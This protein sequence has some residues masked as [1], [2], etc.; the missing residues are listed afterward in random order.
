MLAQ[1]LDAACLAPS[2]GYSQ[3]WRFVSVESGQARAAV[4]SNFER[5]N[6]EALNDYH[7]ERA[8]LYAGL[9]LAGLRVAPVQLAVFTD[10]ATSVGH[11]LGRK[12]MPETLTY[13]TVMAIQN[14][15][16]QR[17][18][19]M[20][21]SGGCRFSIRNCSG[22]ISMFLRHGALRLIYVS[23]IQRKRLIN[24]SS[25]AAA[26]NSYTDPRAKS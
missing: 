10:A 2:V 4:R 18:P 23:A 13:S 3:P 5:A 12:T 15:G 24:R 19:P 14:L 9:K 1:F 21:A 6:A 11:G 16:S 20:L 25:L 26:G 8:R 7:G 22:T 17:A